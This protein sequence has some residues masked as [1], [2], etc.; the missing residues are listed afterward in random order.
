MGY[1]ENSREELERIAKIVVDAAY[2]VH[3]TL[4]PE[5]LEGVYSLCLAHEL[6][7]RGLAVLREVKLP[8]TYDGIRIESALRIDLLVESC[9]IVETKAVETLI[10]VFKA[11]LLTYLKLTGNQLGFLINFN[12]P[13]RSDEYHHLSSRTSRPSRL[14]GLLPSE[15]RVAK[16][17]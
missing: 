7:K 10:P 16:L 8:I 6:R 1:G 12:V 3:S 13:S 5:L 14:R 15:P 4:G 9:V 17:R 2:K 11:Q